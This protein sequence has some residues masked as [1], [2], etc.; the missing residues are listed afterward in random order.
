MNELTYID[1]PEL[2]KREIKRLKVEREKISQKTWNI[3]CR[4]N[5]YDAKKIC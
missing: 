4:F 3:F 5:N 2:F 1:N